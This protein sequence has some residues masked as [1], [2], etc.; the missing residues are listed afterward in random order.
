MSDETAAT[1]RPGDRIT[2]RGAAWTVVRLTPFTD[3][4]ALRIASHAHGRRTLLVPFDRPRAA[5]GS[6]LRVV[7]LRRWMH[8]LR[9]L[10]VETH[11][12]GGLRVCPAGL[13]LLPYQLEPAIAILRDGSARV[14]IA[15]GVGLGKTIQA[16][17][18]VCE[19][20]Q[21]SEAFRALILTPA[22]LRQQWHGELTRHFAI[23]AIGADAQWLRS[24]LREIPADVNP[25]SPPGVYV[26]SFDFVK[27][28]EALRPLEDVR[29]D[30]LVVDEA[31]AA[32][33]GTDRRAAVDAIAKRARRVI[34]LTATPHPGDPDQFAALCRIGAGPHSPPPVF[35]QRR[36]APAAN[37][38]ARRST[39]LMVRPHAA[40]RRMHR[41]LDAYTTR[42]WQEAAG[43]GLQHA[44]LASIVLR[45]RALSSAR[46][47]AVSARRR[48]DLLAAAPAEAFQLLL[49][50]GPLDSDEDPLEDAVPDGALARP[51]LGDAGLE[52]QLLIE[53]AEAAE[54]AS[55][56]ESKVRLLSKLL[57][58]IPEPVIVFTEYRDTLERLAAALAAAGTGTTSIH[59]GMSP[60]ERTQAVAAFNKGR[61]TLLATDAASEGLN[62]Q[63]SCRIVLHYELPWNPLRVEQR[64]GRVDRIGQTRRVHEIALVASDTSESL[65]L[66][67][68]VRRASGWNGCDGLPLRL[69]ES[70]VAEMLIGG[71]AIEQPDT[72]AAAR[73][74]AT[75][76]YV[77]AATAEVTRLLEHRRLRLRR[78]DRSR[79]DTFIPLCLWSRPRDIATGLALIFVL[80]IVDGC[81]SIIH[82]EP[83]AAHVPCAAPESLR[84]AADIKR[85]AVRLLHRVQPAAAAHVLELAQQRIGTARAE[86]QRALAAR[87]QR[88][89]DLSETLASAA[90]QLVQ[91]GLFDRRAVRAV[92]TR[93]RSTTALREQAETA[94]ERLENADRLTASVELR[95]ILIIDSSTSSGRAPSTGSGLA[96]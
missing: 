36:R 65:V 66:G 42:V 9:D 51:G 79:P 35:F 86:Y 20:A 91:A 54:E 48:I 38:P 11:P 92:E 32:T 89:N 59:G 22:G 85:W 80:T 96:P 18:V 6:H 67:P 29:W 71:Q 81:A 84:R 90:V 68:L 19:L 27:R 56:C 12:Y 63:E 10:I 62:L 75:N 49:P 95:A 93:Q 7:R 15:D 40:E 17:L 94:F 13:R 87:R 70:R 52:R 57:K 26:A 30:L 83:V 4:E 28:P 46:S 53:I 74:V 33:I 2:V 37:I 24:V 31:H 45:K 82:T 25:W 8:R 39:L 14:L 43:A 73:A 21:A 44:R 88:E 16:G 78:R 69:T 58:R 23:A 1:W 60:I 50:L 76:D 47:L 72:P 5:P 61:H 34:L 77:D 55:A 3:C 41:L 64:A